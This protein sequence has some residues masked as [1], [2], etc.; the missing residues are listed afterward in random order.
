MKKAHTIID[1]VKFEFSMLYDTHKVKNLFQKNKYISDTV[2]FHWK[3][4]F[5]LDIKYF[6]TFVLLKLIHLL[7][8]DGSFKYM[9][10]IIM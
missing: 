2:L 3:W 10:H 6:T 8:C 4:K 7:Q 5:N 9:S 1:I